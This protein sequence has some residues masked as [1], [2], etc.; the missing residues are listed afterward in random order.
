MR[1]FRQ[2]VSD[3]NSALI[4]NKIIGT[5][6]YASPKIVLAATGS[7]GMAMMVWIVGCVMAWAG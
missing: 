2:N 5:G 4:V 3:L 7:K 6:I 1:S